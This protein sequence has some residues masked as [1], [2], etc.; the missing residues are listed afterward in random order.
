MDGCLGIERSRA[1]DGGG[2]ARVVGR[3][4]EVLGFQ[5]D[6]GTTAVAAAAFADNRRVNIVARVK[7]Q[8]GFC[9]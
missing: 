1:Q 9:C 7:L 5:T 8:G 4:G 2:K 3:V 6:S